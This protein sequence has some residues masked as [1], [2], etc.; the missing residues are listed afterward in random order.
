MLKADPPVPTADQGL[1]PATQNA[2][3]AA[4]IVA[5]APAGRGITS[6]S[7][8]T[9]IAVASALFME[10]IDSTALS[11]A[12][13]TLARAFHT[14]PLH[15]KLALTSYILALAVFAPASGWVA[16]RFGAK[17]V[18]MG[19]MTV[20]LVGSVLCGSSHSLGELVACRLLQGLGGAM[21]TPVGRLIIVGTTPK[22]E[23]VSSMAWFTM[24]AL[25][26]PLLG[27][28]LAGIILGVAEWPWIFYVN[29]PVCIAGLVA[30]AALVPRT[31]APDPGSFDSLGFVYAAVCV[32][33]LVGA[34]ET[35]GVE[36]V[37]RIVQVVGIA[38]AIA[39]GALYLRH[40]RRV[41]RPVLDLSLLRL[42]TFR[43]S[44]VGGTLVR[45]GIGAGP[46]LLPLLLQVALGW[47]P[48]KAGLVS[49]WQ[50]VG[51]LSAKPSAPPLLRRY[52]F[53]TVLVVTVIASAVLTA[54]PGF[55][56]A[57]MPVLLLVGVFVLAGF[58]RSN[59][60]TAANAVAYAEVPHER[61]S[62]A[63][64]LATVTQQVGLSLG[65]SFG[66]TVLHLAKGS[67]GALTPDRFTVP[68]LAVGAV[69]LLAWP[70]YARL[71][72]AAGSSLRG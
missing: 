53:R 40:A 20:F 19:A 36:V 58:V 9:S 44:V 43:A 47:S 23:L 51:A 4:A 24:P 60:F 13:P 54:V 32:S 46:L 56:R 70:V 62:A 30:V 26:G 25:V 68:Y 11:T 35:F 50:S 65:I 10:F 37:P 33:A 71:P 41:K 5:A 2:T 55:F 27:P 6:R 38:L 39:T 69:T 18:F 66:G 22:S 28:P 29:I 7:R 64:T 12:L 57:D 15:L 31:S 34:S 61:I 14:D 21:M 63:S 48:L 72:E 42:P 45:L 8:F 67:G 3:A 1:A 16:D 17:R 52:G 59:Q 49:V